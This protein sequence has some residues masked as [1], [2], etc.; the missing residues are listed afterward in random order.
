[1]DY[2]F[3]ISGIV[4]L[5]LSGNWL[6]KS[7]AELA[8]H[9]K[10]P[11]FIIGV[12]VISM[13]TSAP[14]LFVSLNASYNGYADVAI[15]NIVGSNIANIGLVLAISAVIIAIPIQKATIKL[16][17][18]VLM[19]ATVLLFVF[20]LD[21]K[22][23]R[24][25][26]SIMIVVMIA[27]V[28]WIIRKLRKDKIKG[29]VIEENLSKKRSPVLLGII[30]ITSCVGLV[31][32]SN[33]LVEGAVGIAKVIGISER[34]V[35]ITVIAIGTSLPE[36]TT[37]IIAAVKKNLDISA[38]NVIGSNIFNIL[39]IGGM[40][41]VIKPLNVNPAILHLDIYFMLGFSILLGLFFLPLKTHRISKLEGLFFVM[42]YIGYYVVLFI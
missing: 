16:D 11:P 35:S 5:L 38:G 27:Y 14:E 40:S 12:T 41:S 4:I 29:I 23:T 6:V 19:L 2:L 21:L 37:S 33:L 7:G 18:P 36:L 28:Y 32:G 3:L 15:G 24:I 42:A 30:F 13:G 31:I 1:M 8:S 34:I 22:I 39:V 26:G 17:F 25:E 9:F 20:M 10:I